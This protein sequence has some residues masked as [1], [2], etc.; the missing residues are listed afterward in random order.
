MTS[1]LQASYVDTTAEAPLTGWSKAPFPYAL[2][3]GDLFV[4]AASFVVFMGA[5][6]RSD[7]HPD[8]MTLWTI[9]LLMVWFSFAL[10]LKAYDRDTLVHQF[11]GPYTALK[12]T[13]IAGAVFHLMPLVGAPVDSRVEAVSLV[14][15]LAVVM[16]IW[17]L[18][19][20]FVMPTTHLSANMI[21]VGAGWAGRSL[22]EAMESHP[23]S[24]R[25]ILAFVDA[26]PHLV[27]ADVCGIP[28]FHTSR[29]SAIASAFPYR[30]T[31]ALAVNDEMPAAVYQ[32]LSLLAQHGADVV[33][34]ASVYEQITGRIPVRHL[35]NAWW[36]SLP[37]P[38]TDLVYL[39]AKRFIDIMLALAGLTILLSLIPITWLLNRLDGA[40]PLFFFQTR[41]GQFG[42]PVHV[43]KLRTLRPSTATHTSVWERKRANEASRFG[44][45]LR[46]TGLDELPQLVN[47]LRGEMSIVG[48]R[49]YLGEEVTNYQRLIPFF[50]TRGLV[51]P[52]ITGWAQVNWGYGFDLE[53]EVEKLQYDLYYVGHQSFSLDVQIILR[54]LAVVALRR[55]EAKRVLYAAA[56]P[57]EEPLVESALGIDGKMLLR[58]SLDLVAS[59]HGSERGVSSTGLTIVTDEGNPVAA[60]GKVARDACS[61]DPSIAAA[62]QDAPSPPVG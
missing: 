16:T 24:G 44:A 27:G 19:A 38:S 55:R 11:R 62:R 10:S 8:L 2:A 28:V 3:A 37:R 51:K 22:A 56:P 36:T 6:G 57:A 50:R 30:P 54:T 15:A 12:T 33:P 49:P 13:L 41:E 40:G 53:D 20:S 17:R 58:Q 52:G 39:A 48:P 14:A 31:I 26:D 46:G 61:I 60:C 21:V 4:L 32:D 35:G 25:A 5:T 59:Q 9:V 7:G 29:L 18:A 47:V 1:L 34:M 23:R 45:F 43:V 42:Q